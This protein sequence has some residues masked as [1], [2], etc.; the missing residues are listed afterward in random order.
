MRPHAWRTVLPCAVAML[1]AAAVYAAPPARAVKIAV[2]TPG[3]SFGEALA[4]FR[5]GLRQLGY[6]EN[7]NL[8]WLVEDSSSRSAAMS[9]GSQKKVPAGLLLHPFRAPSPPRPQ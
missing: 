1:L 9:A 7:A 3:L 6:R 4:G 2:P 5:E 8:T